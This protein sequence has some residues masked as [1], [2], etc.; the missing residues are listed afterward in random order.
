MQRG[1]FYSGRGL[2][3]LNPDS[4]RLYT[5]TKIPGKTYRFIGYVVVDT[6]G[7]E[8]DKAAYALKEEAAMLGA[9]AI[10]NFRLTKLTG[11]IKRCGAAGIAVLVQ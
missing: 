9:N 1:L 11:F 6:V 2:S 4:V 5:G 8:G 7:N 3:P 10:V